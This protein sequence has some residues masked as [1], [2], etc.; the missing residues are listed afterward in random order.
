MIKYIHILNS[1]KKHKKPLPPGILVVLIICM[2]S[3]Q[4]LLSQSKA[5]KEYHNYLAFV[6]SEV[7]SMYNFQFNPDQQYP[8]E[9][10]DAAQRMVGLYNFYY[11]YL[12]S[13]KSSIKPKFDALLKKSTSYSQFEN[14]NRELAQLSEQLVQMRYA[15]ARG[16]YFSSA[17]LFNKVGNYFNTHTVDTTISLSRLYWGLYSYYFAAAKEESF[18]IRNLLS[19]W[20]VPKKQI[21]LN[22]LASL[23]DDSSIFIST[24]AR[25]FLMRGLWEIEE[26]PT[27]ALVLANKLCNTYPNNLMYH[28]FRIQIIEDAS[29]VEKAKQEFK[30][31]YL[32]AQ[33]IHTEPAILDLFKERCDEIWD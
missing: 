16:N 32:K 1:G 3:S 9:S 5:N 8:G 29:G 19:Q 2:G 17:I 4:L 12:S 13:D 6:D 7:C 33:S 28:W 26:K 31:Q 10:I 22:A 24:E 15:R 11:Q 30:K 25:Y 21:G 18:I 20:Q 27:E 14:Q 23:I